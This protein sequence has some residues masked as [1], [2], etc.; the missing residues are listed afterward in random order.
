MGWC[1]A[2]AG[3]VRVRRDGLVDN[4]LVLVCL[5]HA[6]SVIAAGAAMHQGAGP[7]ADNARRY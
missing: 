6:H 4:Q 1:C 3:A 2:R 5:V 7:T